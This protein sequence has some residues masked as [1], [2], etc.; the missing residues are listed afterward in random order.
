MRLPH[1]DEVFDKSL[2]LILNVVIAYIILLL[3]IGLIRTLFGI[4]K[5]LEHGD[6]RTAYHEAI[7]EIL[8]FLVIIE[9]FKGF[10]DYF[11]TRRISLTTMTDSAL[12]FVIR[13]LLVSLYAHGHQ[14]WPLLIAFGALIL[15]L[16]V[17]RT[18]AVRFSPNTTATG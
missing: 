18:L 16:G 5:L 10:V 7:I 15:C 1:T 17:V 8:T 4:Q 2:T 14:E 12:V 9:L 6:L 3:N 13:E 11:K